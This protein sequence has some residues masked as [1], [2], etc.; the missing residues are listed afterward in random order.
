MYFQVGD[1]FPNV[2]N[3]NQNKDRLNFKQAG[4]L[5]FYEIEFLKVIL[6]YLVNSE[7]LSSF[8]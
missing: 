8:I 6:S 1:W 2:L 3:I 7:E 5:C 4:H